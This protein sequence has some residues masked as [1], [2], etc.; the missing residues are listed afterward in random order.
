MKKWSEMFPDG[1][2]IFYEG[3]DPKSFIKEMKEKFNFE[4]N[5]NNDRWNKKSGYSFFCPSDLLDKIY[6]SKYPLGS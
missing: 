6:N 4:P 3:S 5:K 2:H 1:R